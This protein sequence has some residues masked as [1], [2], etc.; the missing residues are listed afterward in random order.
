MKIQIDILKDSLNKLLDYTKEAHGET[1]DIDA[2]LYWFV[3][4]DMLVEPAVVPSELTLGSLEDDW[5]Q[6]SAIGDGAREPIGYGL[7]WASA[8]L[9]A[10]GDR[11]L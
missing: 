11:T 2:D 1:V 9:R 10:V 4:R 8:V 7:V 3:P 5:Q 6:I